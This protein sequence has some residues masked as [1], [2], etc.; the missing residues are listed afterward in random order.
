MIISHPE[1]I[2]QAAIPKKNI[3]YDIFANI[4]Q[5]SEIYIVNHS[6]NIL[7]RT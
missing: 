4:R 1:I 7:S 5:I 6:Q 2:V 3:Q